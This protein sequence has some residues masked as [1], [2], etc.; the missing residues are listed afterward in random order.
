MRL[1]LYVGAAFSQRVPARRLRACSRLDDVSFRRLGIYD[2]NNVFDLAKQNLDNQIMALRFSDTELFT[3]P[4][5][6]NELQQV[7]RSFG[8]KTQIQ[9]P[10]AVSPELFADLYRRATKIQTEETAD[11]RENSAVVPSL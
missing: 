6:W 4:I 9:F 1:V 5:E 2:W 7:L 10:V 8:C 11:V 3:N